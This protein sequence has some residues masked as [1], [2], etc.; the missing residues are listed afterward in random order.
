[1]KILVCFF[2]FSFFMF[3]D[4]TDSS[5]SNNNKAVTTLDDY[6]DYSGRDDELS[7][8]VKMIP[9]T[10]PK[11]NF[12]VWTKR[13]G[14]NPRVKVLLLHG[15][16]GFSHEYL[17]CFD[18]FF[19]KEG[20]E[21]YYYDQL[22]SYYSDQPKD[23][24]LWELDR[25]VDEVEQVRKAL[26]LDKNNFYLYGQSWGGLL[27]TEYA[28]KY[29]E[30]LKGLIISNMMISIPDYIKY[31][32]DV[33]GPQ[34]DPS[35]LAEIK[36]FEANGDYNNP[37]Y[38]ELVTTY[39]YPEHILRMP[40][41]SWPDPVNRS[42]KHLNPEVYVPMQGQSEFGVSRNA[43]LKNWDR[44]SDLPKISVPT[45]IIGAEYDTMDPEHMRG[46]ASQVQQGRYLHCPN[47]SHLAMYDDQKIYFEGLI[48]FIKDVDRGSF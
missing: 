2:L 39:Y 16:P 27:A 47:G 20:I 15:G 26:N 17:E 22:G 44:K 10:T 37:R 23:S 40:L 29:Q 48:K 42:F 6:F 24:S 33:L 46:V 36:E 1:M 12:K 3:Y 11:G 31:A 38:M 8:G 7:G 32:E 35:I 14:N 34:L 41:E 21:Y 45:L 18:S 4:C 9:I 5:D 28:L 25:F 43:K 13:V 30:N 19:P